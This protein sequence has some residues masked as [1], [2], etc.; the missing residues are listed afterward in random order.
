[1]Q[2][3]SFLE[4]INTY[5]FPGICD[6]IVWNLT[7][8]IR[9]MP[10]ATYVLVTICHSLWVTYNSFML[11]DKVKYEQTQNNVEEGPRI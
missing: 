6:S 1:M 11:I 4:Q 5:L 7:T 3:L 8:K 9:Y 2:C 10:V